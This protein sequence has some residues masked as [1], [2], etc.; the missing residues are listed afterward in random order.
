[1]KLY[2]SYFAQ[3]RNFPANLI[4]LS[5]AVWNPKWLTPNRDKNGA[6]WLDCPP[7]KPGIEC[8][9]LCNGNCLPKNPQNCL[10]LQAYRKQLNK[11]EYTVIISKLKNLAQKIAVNENLQEVNFAFLVYEKYNNPCSERWVIQEWFRANGAK[12]EEWHI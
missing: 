5:T 9:G 2:T 6:I 11:L 3:L 10:F 7:F 4:G 12:I 1:M 8:A